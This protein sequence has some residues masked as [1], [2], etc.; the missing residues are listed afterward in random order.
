MRLAR[1]RAR[2]SRANEHDLTKVEGERGSE[3]GRGSEVRATKSHERNGRDKR[4]DEARL[5]TVVRV[6]VRVKCRDDRRERT[7]RAKAKC[8]R[9]NEVKWGVGYVP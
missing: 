7:T 3:R 5:K 6:Q 9:L 1:E 8:C 2:R 4:T